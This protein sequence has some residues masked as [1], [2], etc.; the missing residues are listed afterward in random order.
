MTGR[1]GVEFMVKSLK[2]LFSGETPN[3]HEFVKKLA[4]ELEKV[5]EDAVKLLAKFVPDELKTSE[6]KSASSKQ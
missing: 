2:K 6:E 3:I 1:K 5:T 4:T